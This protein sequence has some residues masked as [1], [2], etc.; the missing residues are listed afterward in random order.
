VRRAYRGTIQVGIGVN[1]G[2]VI[3]GTVGGG[4]RLDFTVI[5]DPVNTASRVEEL[6]RTTG[7][8]VLITDATRRLLTADHGGFDG[9]ETGELRGKRE[10]VRV[11]APR[12]L[13]VGA[14]AS[15]G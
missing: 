14:A 11:F 3:A 1:S 13:A 5:G 9:R 8:P 10:V 12:V 6:T 2:T 15:A 4:G 7:D